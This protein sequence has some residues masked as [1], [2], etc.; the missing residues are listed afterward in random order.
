MTT[1]M[2][3]VTLSEGPYNDR[4]LSEP[5]GDIRC[6][7]WCGQNKGRRDYLVVEGT[8]VWMRNKATDMFFDH[9]GDIQDILMTEP[10]DPRRERGRQHATYRVL[11]KLQEIPLRIY[12]SQGEHFTHWAVLRHIGI[13]PTKLP[14]MTE[15]IYS[16]AVADT[17][18]PDEALREL[19]E[20]IKA[21]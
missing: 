21:N 13:L 2:I 15:G 8:Q 20:K 6:L 9:V 19:V 18:P 16:S 4:W 14:S 11:V 5:E 10:N 3:F 17:T 12:R 1:S 7:Q